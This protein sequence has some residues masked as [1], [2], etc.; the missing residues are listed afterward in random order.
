MT[1]E[2]LRQ[3]VGDAAFYAALRAF[4]AEH[5]GGNATTADFRAV[6]ERTSGQS[7]T[8]F[9]DVWLY[10]PAKPTSW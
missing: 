5:A 7:L 6:A 9:F 1:L 8:H 4:A 2:A 3:K 10:Q